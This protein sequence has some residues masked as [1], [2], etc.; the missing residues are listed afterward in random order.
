M[1]RGRVRQDPYEAKD[2]SVQRILT[3]LKEYPDGLHFEQL[4]KITKLHQDT[5]TVR[6]KELVDDGV[7]MHTNK[8]Y[9]ISPDGEDDLSRR[10]LIRQI[11]STGGMVVVGG[12]SNLSLYPDED[13]IL[14][15]TVGYAFPAISPGVVGALRRVLHKYW[16][17]HL[18]TNLAS[19]HKIDPRCLTGEKPVEK[20]IKELK[21][22]VTGEKLVLAFIIDQRELKKRLN[23]EYVQ[24]IVRLAKVE[25][26]N[27]I[28]TK[29][30]EFVETFQRYSGMKK[31][32]H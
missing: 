12:D 30:S 17:L 16:M 26:I 9:K 7:V 13:V 28:E 19:H 18:M 2:D 32:S 3:A 22:M 20:M 10:R 11:D 31:Q 23:R 24:E 29:N 5:L 15:S 21:S 25:D 8:L 14:N 27:H 4:K 6:L 1:P